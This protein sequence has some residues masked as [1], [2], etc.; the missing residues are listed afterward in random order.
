MNCV[1]CKK[2][3]LNLLESGLFDDRYGSSGK[4]SV[5]QCK[6]CSL[7]QTYPRLKKNEIPKI[8][9]K[10]YPL[11]KFTPQQVKSSISKIGKVGSWL[12]GID[13][14]AHKQI[15]PHNLV[16]DIG[17]GSGVSLLEIKDQK[18][19]GYGVEPDPMAQKIAR[20]LNLNVFQGEITNNPFP[21]LKF[22]VVTASQVIEH[23]SDPALFLQAAKKKLKP[24]GKII[25]STPNLNSLTR[26]MLG[27]K[28]LHWHVPFH[29]NL[30]TLK[31]LNHLAKINNL[32]I[33][34]VRTITPNLW[35]L[36]QI[37]SL[38]KKAKHGVPNPIWDNP[39]DSLSP[40]RSSATQSMYK[41]VVWSFLVAC[42]PFNRLIDFLG[43]GESWL[44]FLETD[45]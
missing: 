38:V 45:K 6:N 17:S 7:G 30:F 4:Y 18:S 8:Y 12:L 24:A 34:R 10:Y 1:L 27:R 5:L 42:I 43:L 41:L 26:K 20:A 14:I 21:K 13:N 40:N 3:K 32:K 33:T 23:V 44:V 29:Q 9:S 36:L 39:T 35:T 28:W 15:K 37:R 2:T 11:S 22:D 25:L 31:S 16:L 19:T